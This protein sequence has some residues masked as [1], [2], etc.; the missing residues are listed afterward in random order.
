VSL[1]HI[2]KKI[3]TLLLNIVNRGV[4]PYFDEILISVAV[5]L[6]ILLTYS[7]GVMRNMPEK[8]GI[9]F[10]DGIELDFSEKVSTGEGSSDSS[11]QG[12]YVASK[13]GTKYYLATCSGAKRIKDENKIYFSTIEAAESRGLGPAKNC[14]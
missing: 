11:D 9:S 12:P 6:T 14:F 8:A 1:K 7:Y 4:L 3:K 13:N 2:T 10:V 5:I